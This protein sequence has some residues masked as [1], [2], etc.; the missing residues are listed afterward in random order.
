VKRSVLGTSRAEIGAYLLGLWGLPLPIIHA[1][2]H[3][4]DADAALTPV[5]AALRATHAQLASRGGSSQ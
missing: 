3:H 2:A 5:L 4:N 1:I